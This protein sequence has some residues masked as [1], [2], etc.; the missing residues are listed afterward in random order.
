MGKGG[1]GEKEKKNFLYKFPKDRMVAGANL[2]FLDCP[3]EKTPLT[4]RV[5]MS[6]F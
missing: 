5:S 6:R 3:R 1:S 4:S 2:V